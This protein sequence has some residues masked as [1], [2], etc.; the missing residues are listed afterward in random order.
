M[1]DCGMMSGRRVRFFYKTMEEAEGKAAQMRVARQNEGDGPFGLSAHFRSDA[2]KAHELL[3]PHKVT[4]LQAAEFY[5]AHVD[6]IRAAKPLTECIQELLQQ[7]QADGRAKAYLD[8]LTARLRTFSASF[9]DT[10]VSDFTSTQIDD[11]LRASQSG[12]VNRNNYR[13]VLSVL[14]SFA[15]KRHYILKNPLKEVEVASVNPDKP[16]ILSLDESRALLQSA[17]PDFLPCIALGLFAGL[18]PE[19]EVWRLQW[20]QID[21][22]G[23]EPT[24]DIERSKNVASHRFVRIADNLRAW[25]SPYAKHAGPVFPFGTEAYYRRLGET[26]ARALE[27][28][29]KEGM[30]ADNLENWAGD[31]LRHTFASNHYAAFKNAHDTAEQLGHAGNMRMFFRH[32]RNR[33]KQPDALAFWQIVPAADAPAP[34]RP[35]SSKQGPHPARVP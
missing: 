32:Y 33:V 6:T 4:L 31:C 25:L 34:S 26:R 9:P 11:W 21:L 5:L 17:R 20:K 27:Q 15:V 8:D 1:V 10:L 29:E 30:P 13:R 22:N 7:K 2:I 28:L 14:F 35:S 12:P 3:S 23:E 16:G 18:R 19:A 24:I